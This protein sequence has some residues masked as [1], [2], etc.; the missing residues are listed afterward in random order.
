MAASMLRAWRYG[1]SVVSASKA[2]ATAVI[3]PD[4]RD[5]VA[6]EALRVAAA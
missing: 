3:R 6:A 4:Q 2:S 1:R 5:V